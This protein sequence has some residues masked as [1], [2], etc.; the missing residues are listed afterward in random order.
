MPGQLFFFFF[1]KRPFPV[2]TIPSFSNVKP[3]K[4]GLNCDFLI[5]S[6]TLFLIHVFFFFF[7]SLKKKTSLEFPK[8]IS[9]E[10]PWQL[11]GNFHKTSSQGV[12]RAGLSILSSHGDR[13]GLCLNTADKREGENQVQVG[14]GHTERHS[15]GPESVLGIGLALFF[16][17]CLTSEKRPLVLLTANLRSSCSVF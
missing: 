8:T 17:L 12:N 7:S 1:L 2:T 10:L 3:F 15:H 6:E 4:S 9:A 5:I 16:Y 14:L 13:P 11:A